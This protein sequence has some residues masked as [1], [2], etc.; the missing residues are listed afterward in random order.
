MEIKTDTKAKTK[1]TPYKENSSNTLPPTRAPLQPFRVYKSSP[2]NKPNE[3]WWV[4]ATTKTTQLGKTT[5]RMTRREI[6]V[7]K[8]VEELMISKAKWINLIA[9]KKS[10]S[11]RGRNN[12]RGLLKAIC[13]LPK[14]VK[15]RSK[16][17]LIKCRTFNL[18]PSQS[19]DSTINKIQIQPI[20]LLSIPNYN[21]Q[22]PATPLLQS[23]VQFHIISTNLNC[24]TSRRCKSSWF[25]IP[26]IIDRR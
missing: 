15:I 26:E 17:A 1:Q 13:W 14:S 8:M 11:V 4:Q 10:N 21:H 12:R 20:E 6:A 18:N 7:N 25:P 24:G 5:F 2:N 9:E 19:Q 23:I 16:M 3:L 22:K